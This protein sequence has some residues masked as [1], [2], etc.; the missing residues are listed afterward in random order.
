MSLIRFTALFFKG[1]R[2]NFKIIRYGDVPDVYQTPAILE[3]YSFASPGF[4][5]FVCSAK[6]LARHLLRRRL[7]VYSVPVKP[8]IYCGGS[9]NNEREFSFFSRLLTSDLPIS[10][11]GQ[12]QNLSFVSA[13]EVDKTRFEMMVSVA[14]F[15]FCLLYLF[16]I[17]VGPVSL[18]YLLTYSK[19]F[20]QVYAST[21]RQQ[22]NVSALVVAN[23]HTD[24]PVAASMVMQYLHVPVVYVQ[25]AEISSAFPQLDF[26]VS[27]L[28]NQKSLD[29]YR[30]IGPVPG[31]VFVIPRRE[32]S[33]HF[34]KMLESRA[35]EVSVVVYLSSVFDE[36]VVLRCVDALRCNPG[37]VNV[38]IKPH[39]RANQEFLHTVRGVSIYDSIPPFE[40][41][42]IVPNS[43]VVIELLEAGTPVFQY[44]QLD[45]VGHDYYGFVSEGVAPEVSTK[46]LSGSFWMSEFYDDNWVS[47]FAAYSP[48][49][50]DSWRASVPA[51]IAKM[52]SYLR[53]TS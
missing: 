39:P 12:E 1:L 52:E 23:D 21:R 42:A 49:V 31:D 3:R 15:C 26:S 50:D 51:L 5:G 46:D 11:Y 13:K 35:Q 4:N 14:L 18:K 24:F 28:R 45:G 19:V 53:P 17:R 33:E 43:S 10:D 8:F 2:R 9:A 7:K 47:K 20:L 41:V 30:A 25:H 6:E 48:A 38:G 36:E 34:M 32:K 37:V 44:F 16:R 40:H 22:V 29:I 27:V